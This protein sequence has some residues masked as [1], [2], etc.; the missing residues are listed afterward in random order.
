MQMR[1]SGFECLHELLITV[2]KFVMDL[3]LCGR[4][5]GESMVCTC[6]PSTVSCL[7]VCRNASS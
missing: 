6:E 1:W 5:G 4:S 2:S 7:V 3:E